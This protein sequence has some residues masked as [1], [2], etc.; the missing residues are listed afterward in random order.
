[1]VNP[2]LP[3]PNSNVFQLPTTINQPLPVQQSAF[4]PLNVPQNGATWKCPDW[5]SNQMHPDSYMNFNGQRPQQ[6]LPVKRKAAPDPE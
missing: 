1:M 2:E 3:I 6:A 5:M 4:S